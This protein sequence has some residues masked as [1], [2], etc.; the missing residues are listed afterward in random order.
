MAGRASSH[1]LGANCQGNGERVEVYSGTSTSW[2]LGGSSLHFGVHT[3]GPVRHLWAATPSS[4]AI[5]LYGVGRLRRGA[6]GSTAHILGVLSRWNSR[7]LREQQ[8]ARH[9]FFPAGRLL[10]PERQGR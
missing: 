7:W 3:Q 6:E 5:R 2:R 8:H 1:G 4:T 9:D 10:E